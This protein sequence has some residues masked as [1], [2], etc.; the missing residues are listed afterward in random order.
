MG[1]VSV[2][3]GWGV[4]FLNPLVAGECNFKLGNVEICDGF[5]EWN[6][7]CCANTFCFHCVCDDFRCL[8]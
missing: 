6:V 3:V 1:K 4:F 8:I 7:F 5:T 2:L